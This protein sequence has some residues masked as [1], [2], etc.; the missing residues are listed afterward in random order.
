LAGGVLLLLAVLAELDRRKM[1]A[2]MR[3][4]TITEA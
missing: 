2:A 1:L 4:A 3:T